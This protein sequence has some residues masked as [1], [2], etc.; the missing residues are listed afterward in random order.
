M[1]TRTIRLFALLLVSAMYWQ[2]V[3][4]WSGVAEP[5][6]A[7]GYWHLWYPVS[8]ALSAVA[9]FVLRSRWG[10][11][12][13]VVTVAQLPVMAVHAQPGAL[14][15]GGVMILCILAIPAAAVSALAGR[16]RPRACIDHGKG[17]DGSL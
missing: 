5:W 17:G 4:R 15:I 8:L 11:A 12:G 7:D 13:A 1:K 9:G 10:L 14:M 2:L 6:D 16:L 3:S